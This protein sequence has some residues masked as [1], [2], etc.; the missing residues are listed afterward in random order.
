MANRNQYKAEQFINAIKGSGGIVSTIAKRVGCDWNTAK[1]Y[2]D[3]MPTIKAAYDA[4]C[5]SVLDLAEVKLI[6]NI[7][8]G[9]MGAIKYMLSTKGKKRGYVEK[10]QV[11][12]QSIT[13]N[14]D[15]LNSLSDEQ[16]KRL[17]AGENIVDILAD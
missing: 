8:D 5:E 17:A 7:E 1:K 13:L 10:Q 16:L 14:I 12:Q 6:E 9:D 11:E 15:D 3:T 2:V 4:E